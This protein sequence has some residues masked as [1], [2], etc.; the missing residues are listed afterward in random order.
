VVLNFF[1]EMTILFKTT[2]H[3]CPYLSVK[4]LIQTY[5]EKNE[6]NEIKKWDDNLI[7]LICLCIQCPPL[8]RITLG[9]H[10]SDNNNK[11]IKTFSIEGAGWKFLCACTSIRSI[12]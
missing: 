3:G 1:S 9:Q 5:L 11:K 7:I 12:N 4:R 10:K 2:L 8:N 6:K